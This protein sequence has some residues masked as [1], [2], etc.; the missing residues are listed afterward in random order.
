MQPN[1]PVETQTPVDRRPPGARRALSSSA[2]GSV[3]EWFDFAIYGAL[4]ASVF[5]ML[6]FNQADPRVAVLASFATFGVGFLARPLGGV[7]FGYLGDKIGRR[8]VLMT[9]FVLMGVASLAIAV[10]P[11]YATWGL[12]SPAI[13]V[14]VRFVQGFALG[15]ETTGAQLMALEY[16]PRDRRAFYGSLIG[17][18]SP[19][20]QVLANLMLVVLSAT[21]SEEA[22]TSWG[23]RIPLALSIVLIVIGVYV[24]NRLDETPIF[25]EAKEQ[26]TQHHTTPLT[27]VR[28]HGV[29]I[30]RLALAY[31]PIVVT[32]YVVTVYGISYMTLDAGFST[33]ESF[34]TVMI[35]NTVACAAVLVGGRMA[36]RIGRRKVLLYGSGVCLVS[37]LAYFPLVDTGNFTIA[38][39]AATVAVSGAQFG[40]GAQPALFAEAFPTH[41]RFTGVALAV[42]ISTVVF[43]ASAP[44]AASALGAATGGTSLIAGVWA[45]VVAAAMINLALMRDGLSL[46]GRQQSY[47]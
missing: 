6:F 20:S 14:F 33:G 23:W 27:V 3:V 15:G 25:K 40:N 34:L 21:M 18:G 38:L 19:A 28:S 46:E 5:P 8:N 29:M 39:L 45:V 42:N 12:L 37:A 44:F 32:F 16:A 22:F 2:L 24:R 26:A 9:T 41:L 43:G 4:A 31:A 47:R 36:D 13:L 35:A 11:G 7:F 10:L 30:L 1:L 17:L